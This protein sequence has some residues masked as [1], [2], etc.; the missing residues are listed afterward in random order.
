M[1]PLDRPKYRERVD[2]T[3]DPVGVDTTDRRDIE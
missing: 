1:D 3:V 2:E